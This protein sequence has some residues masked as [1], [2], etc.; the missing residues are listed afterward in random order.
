MSAARVVTA[1]RASI[2]HARP[3]NPVFTASRAIRTGSPQPNTSRRSPSLMPAIDTASDSPEGLKM[4]NNFI[5]RRPR[6]DGFDAPLS[7]SR[8]DD[9]VPGCE[10]SAKN[11]AGPGKTRRSARRN[12]GRQYHDDRRCARRSPGPRQPDRLTHADGYRASRQ[13]NRSPLAAHQGVRSARVARRC[14]VRRMGYFRGQLVRSGEDGRRAR[15]RISSIRSGRSS[16]PSSRCRPCSID[17]TSSGSTGRTSRRGRTSAIS[18]ISCA[19]TCASS[20]R[21]TAAIVW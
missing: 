15:S 14:G 12:G 16:K 9:I 10:K 18:P 8:T 11:R 19:R 6:A 21:T 5:G 4:S 1:S 7:R 17:A 13:A 20:S 3:V 2:A